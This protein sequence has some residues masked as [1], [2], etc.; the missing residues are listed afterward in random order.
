M[1]WYNIL[2]RGGKRQRF[3][4][5]GNTYQEI[6]EEV[7]GN[8]EM[9]GYVVTRLWELF[10]EAKA[11]NDTIDAEDIEAVEKLRNHISSNRES[12]PRITNRR[13]K[14]LNILLGNMKKHD[15]EVRRFLNR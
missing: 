8:T 14:S 11:H 4:I 12:Y 9:T 7:I 15:S 2:K 13:Q 3:R 5:A 6:V 10:N 1:T